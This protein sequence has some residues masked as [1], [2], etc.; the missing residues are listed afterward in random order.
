MSEKM[1][2]APKAGP[3]RMMGGG[4]RPAVGMASEKP[5]NFKASLGKLIRALSIYKVLIILT[6]VFAMASTIFGIAS[7]KIL[8]NMTNQIVDDYIA[9]KAYD[10]VVEGLPSGIRLP[11]GTTIETLSET[12]ESMVRSGELTDI[13]MKE[14]SERRQQSEETNGLERVPEAQLDKIKTLDLSEK[15]VMHYDLLIKTALILVGLYVASAV[16][17]FVQGW[18]IAGVTNKVVRKFRKDLSEKINR[19]PIGYF[20]RHPYGD[21]LSRVTND[22]DTVAQSLNQSLSQ[23]VTS[24]TTLVGI[25]AMMVSISVQMTFIAV[26]TLP[27]GFAF[28]AFVTKNSQKHFKNQQDYLGELNGHI[29]EIYAGQTIVKAFSGEG[30]AIK[31]FNKVNERLH[32]SA[33]KAQFLSGLMMPIMHFISNLGYVAS[34]VAGGWLAINGRI[35]IGD[36]QAFIQ[37]VHQLNH[38]MVQVAQIMNVLQSTVAASERVFDFLEEGEETEE[39]KDLESLG[40]TLGEVEFRNV[41]FG[42]GDGKDVI[43]GFSAKITPGQKVAIVGPTGAGKTTVVNLLMRFYDPKAGQILIDGVDTRTMRRSDVRKQFG[44]VLQDTWLFNGTINENLTYGDLEA[45]RSKILRASKAAHVD[46][47]VQSLPQGYKT[48]LDED[49]DNISVGEKQLLTIARAMVAE[50][51]MMI[52]DEATSSVDTRTEVLIQD[53]M[54][55]LTKGRTSFVIAHRLSTIRNADVIL[56][57]NDG[58]VVEQG[59]HTELMKQNGFYANLYRS[60]FAKELVNEI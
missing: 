13:Q 27:I 3:P 52:L 44:M 36:I 57:M 21:T 38:P 5:K 50:R 40:E 8:G 20:D 55:K 30:K 37:Y 16:F 47:F 54:E 2:T 28:I 60:Q 14:L 25:I 12:I 58:N 43:K 34:V 33:W 42:Y 7:P 24:I 26:L 17:G 39:T 35:S 59:N 46:H 45:K 31:Q 9:I 15:P 18:V 19:L 10:G 11:K 51:P 23:V 53:A 56:V 48:V 1:T 4:V 29:E 49:S 41:V 6:V 22:V 32:T